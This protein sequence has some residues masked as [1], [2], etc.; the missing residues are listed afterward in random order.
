MGSIIGMAA[1]SVII[2][3]PLRYSCNGLT[4]L[5]NGLQAIVGIAT[6]SLGTL[7]AINYL[8]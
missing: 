7:T 3:I 1:L 8:T 2:A 6:L 5:Y 4:W